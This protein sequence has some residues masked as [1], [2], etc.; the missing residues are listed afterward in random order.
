MKQHAKARGPFTFARSKE[1][2]TDINNSHKPNSS[3]CQ[4]CLAHLNAPILFSSLLTLPPTNDRRAHT[5]HAHAAEKSST[6]QNPL[7]IEIPRFIRVKHR[8]L[9]LKTISA[10]KRAVVPLHW[11][12][13]A[14]YVLRLN[15][16]PP[17]AEASWSVSGVLL[18]WS[19]T[20]SFSRS[21]RSFSRS[22]P[23]S[24]LRLCKCSMSSS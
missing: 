12:P 1:S 14:T 21:W 9:R 7:G 4:S 8:S 20:S 15:Q 19:R 6:L 10:H 17:E 2:K 23:F 24:V 16:H 22:W 13:L 3:F 5:I 18:C 11:I